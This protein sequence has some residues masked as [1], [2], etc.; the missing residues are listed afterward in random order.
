MNIKTEIN[1][2][3]ESQLDDK[4]CC[5]GDDIHYRYLPYRPYIEIFEEEHRREIV[6]IMECLADENNYPIYFHCLAGGDRTGMIAL[7]LR[8]LLGESDEDI[9]TDYELTS[10]SSYAYQLTDGEGALGF[11]SRFSEGFQEF[12]SVFNT[13]KGE[14]VGEHTEAFL[15]ECGVP[16]ETIAK[17]RNNLKK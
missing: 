13:Y 5:V 8:G 16:P 15:L 10:L 14:T 17:I 4:V 9:L 6:D 2:R 3:K 7:F 12:L 1:L 11:R